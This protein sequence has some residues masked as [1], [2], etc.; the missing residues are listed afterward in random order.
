MTVVCSEWNIIYLNDLIYYISS[1]RPSG[2]K[3][4]IIA[5]RRADAPEFFNNR[6]AFQLR[7]IPWL[8]HSLVMQ[9]CLKG[10]EWKWVEWIGEVP[11]IT[12]K[13]RHHGDV[14]LLWRDF[15]ESY[16]CSIMSCWVWASLTFTWWVFFSVS[17]LTCHL[18]N[19]LLPCPSSSRVSVI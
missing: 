14:G 7:F 8:V 19:L 13:E 5:G 6:A 17:L 10:V 15:H 2:C 12:A 4:L 16:L 11:H 9:S 18:S 3:M 1:T